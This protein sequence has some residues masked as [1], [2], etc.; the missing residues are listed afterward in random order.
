MTLMRIFWEIILLSIWILEICGCEEYSA[1]GVC[2]EWNGMV[3]AIP[4]I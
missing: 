2:V 4:E 3:D 1:L